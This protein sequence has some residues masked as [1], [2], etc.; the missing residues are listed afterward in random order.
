[1]SKDNIVW[2]IYSEDNKYKEAYYDSISEVIK[3]A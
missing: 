3:V 2:S 1:M